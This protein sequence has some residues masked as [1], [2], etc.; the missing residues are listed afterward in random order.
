MYA[1]FLRAC[2]TLTLVFLLFSPLFPTLHADD[3]AAVFTPE[4]LRM[5]FFDDVTAKARNLA[6]EAYTP[7]SRNLPAVLENLDYDQYRAI[8]FRPEA[9]LWRGQSEF[10]I[11]LFHPGFLFR[12]P[13]SIHEV[14]NN[15]TQGI[16]FRPDFFS[17]DGPAT[18]LAGQVPANTGFAGFRVHY[19]L[20]NKG[21]KDEF[22]VFQGASYFRLV[23]PGQAYGLSA[24][25]LAI[26]TAEGKGEEFPVFKEFWLEKPSA[27]DSRLVFYALLDSKSITGAYRFEVSPG[28]PTEVHIQAELFARVN[29]QKL[30]VAPLTSM[31]M[32][33]ENRTRFYDDFRPEVHDSDGVLMAASNGEWIWR[34]LSNHR[35]LHVSSLLDSNPKGFGLLQ[36][37][38]NFDHYLDM[39]A[40]YEQRPS[41]WITPQGNWGKGRVELVEIPSDSEVNDNIVAYWVPET[42]MKAGEHRRFDY[43]LRTFDAH[44]TENPYA[45]VL[46]TQIGWG[47]NPGQANPP[48]KSHRRFV[49]DFRGGD[50]ENFSANGPIEPQL[51]VNGGTVSDVLLQ[52]LA[53][54]KTWRVSFMLAPEAG[55]ADMR[56]FLQIG[57][58][59]ASEVWSYVWYADAID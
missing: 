38:R 1:V 59:R 43:S 49:V 48:P 9:A 50:L 3:V 11:Q 5:S 18:K 29:I 44:V 21:Y 15:Q 31:F 51:Q 7:P 41:I 6:A 23:G 52:R 46:R 42:P 4:M 19:P 10:E 24:R 8:R 36:R 22:L 56:L 13:V 57:Q 54:N 25:G 40:K 35:H 12:E 17:Y 37:D 20:N 30:G 27:T 28:A 45:R 55:P 16:G 14:E 39:E 58:K 33:G 2:K 53:D 32:W 47:G 26:D 34:P